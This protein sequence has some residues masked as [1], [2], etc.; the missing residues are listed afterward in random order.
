MLNNLILYNMIF[1]LFFS[2]LFIIGLSLIINV[3]YNTFTFK[4]DHRL[5]YIRFFKKLSLNISILVFILVLYLN[6][7]FDCLS[8]KEQ[9]LCSIGDI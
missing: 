8:C 6:L 1:L 3:F 2:S 5:I 7:N 9:Y 4:A